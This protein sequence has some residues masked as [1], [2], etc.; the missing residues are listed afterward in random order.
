MPII[1]GMDSK[2]LE[3][4]TLLNLITSIGKVFMLVLIR[5]CV[6]IRFMIQISVTWI[7]KS[8]S[9]IPPSLQK[10]LLKRNQNCTVLNTF[11]EATFCQRLKEI[12]SSLPYRMMH[13]MSPSVLCNPFVAPL[14]SRQVS[15]PINPS[16]PASPQYDWAHGLQSTHCAA[17]CLFTGFQHLVAPV[18]NCD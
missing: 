10:P 7:W 2:I 8:V 1:S 18:R 15:L 5:S 16:C 6:M 9:K 11:T 4:L 17:Q 12:L 13:L 3:I 14:A